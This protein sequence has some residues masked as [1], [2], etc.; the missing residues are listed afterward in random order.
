MASSSHIEEIRAALEKEAVSGNIFA[1]KKAAEKFMKAKA[2]VKAAKA[3]KKARRPAACAA[4]K[5]KAAANAAKA[6]KEAIKGKNACLECGGAIVQAAYG[7]DFGCGTCG[8]RC[9]PESAEE[10]EEYECLECGGAIVQAAY[11]VDLGCGSCGTR[12]EL[13]CLL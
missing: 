11:G 4:E 6:S 7:L 3:T 10:S 12:F 8:T 13:G 1:R 9:E 5:K 2:L